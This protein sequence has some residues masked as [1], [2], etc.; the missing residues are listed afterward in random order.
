MLEKQKF[1][2]RYT[3]LLH[4]YAQSAEEKYL[5][6]I[7]YLGREMVRDHLPPEYVG[8]MHDAAMGKLLA[9]P[10]FS[11]ETIRAASLPLMQL[12]NAYG[13]AFRNV[14]PS[15]GIE[16]ALVESEKQYQMLFESSRDAIMIL[17]EAGFIRGNASAIRMFGCHCSDDF[18]GRHPAEF[19][20]PAQPCGTESM[21]LANQHIARALTDGSISFEWMHQ[22]LDGEVFPA[23]VLLSALEL[24]GKSVLQATVR[25]ISVRKQAE[26]SVRRFSSAIEQMG[27]SVVIT[28]RNGIIE[29]ANPAF[30]KV[31]GYSAE[32]AI[33]QTPGMLNSG[34]QDAAFYK[35]MWQ[36][37]TQGK[38]WKGKIIDRRKDGSFYPAMLTISPII[39]S[40]L[41]ITHFVGIQ[42]DL[43]QLEEMEH[44]FQQAQKME[45]IGTMVGGIAHNFNNMLAGMAGNIYLAKKAVQ[46][47]PDVMRKLTNIEELSGHAADMIQ[48]LLAFARKDMVSMKETPLSSFINETLKLLRASVPENIAVQQD[49][50]SDDFQIKGDATQLHQVLANLINNARDAVENVESPCITI[51]LDSFSPDDSFLHRRPWFKD[52]TFAHL[53]VEDNGMGIS[54]YQLEHLFEPFFTSKQHGKGTGLGLSMVYGAVKTHNGF[55]DVSSQEGKGSTFHIYIPLLEPKEGDAEPVQRLE[56]AEGRGELIL[57]ADDEQGVRDVMAKVLALLGYKVLQ[58]GDGLE[59]L[60]LFKAHQQDIALALL[61]VVMPHCGGMALAKHIREVNPDVPV[62]FLTGYDKEYVLGGDEAMPNSEV[63]TKPVNFDTLN[64][65]I[66]QLLD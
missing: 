16:Q 28:D 11:V 50:C 14:R 12:L 13:V 43:S 61:D 23:E 22:S 10:Q 25:D 44:R 57:L 36:T 29:Y 7:A 4:A 2:R 35:V 39:D 18:Q 42:S 1:I 33:G 31:T 59:A 46:A 5:A 41:H 56:A 40:S 48:Q 21:I 38:V 32:E 17:D 34:N 51:G 15:H 60:E 19:S 3:E 47:Q 54:E 55:V 65:S 58:A 45:T 49:I 37:I 63:L 27:E 6:D 20:P 8:E 24:E 66:R 52:G 9:Q 30:T 53:S 64:Y 26:E 62:I